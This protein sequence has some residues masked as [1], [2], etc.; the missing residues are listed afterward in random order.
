MLRIQRSV[1]SGVVFSLSGHIETED[2]AELQRILDL[3]AVKNSV[4]LDLQDVTIV[5]RDALQFLARCEA[6][7]IKLQNVPAYVRDWLAT[8]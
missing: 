5:E 6:D 7:G 8:E 1:N 3:E 2:V 4:S